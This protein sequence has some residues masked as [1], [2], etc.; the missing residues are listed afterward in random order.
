MDGDAEGGGERS[1]LLRLLR[2]AAHEPSRGLTPA[3]AL[4]LSLARAAQASVDLPLTV[5]AVQEEMLPLEAALDRLDAE[6]LLIAVE[7]PGGTAGV[8]AID[9]Q[10]RCAVVEMQTLCGLD[11]DP[12]TGRAI[13]ATDV[14]LCAPLVDAMLADLD[15]NGEATELAGWTAGMAAGARIADIRRAGLTLSSGEMRLVRLTVDLG[16]EGREGTFAMVLPPAA[17]PASDPPP[18]DTFGPR[19]RD[20]VMCAPADL[21]AVLHRMRMTW[22]EVETLTVGQVLPLAGITV[23]SVRLEGTGGRLVAQARLGRAAGL[24]AVRIGAAAPMRMEEATVPRRGMA[25]LAGADGEAA[26]A[27]AVKTASTTGPA[28]ETIVRAPLMTG[29]GDAAV[30]G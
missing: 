27:E 21:Q 2:G 16:A 7:G 5:I 1:I 17:R 9:A 23:G 18:A 29:A 30:T 11:R 15:R 6:A 12:A 14:A 19:L 13:S 22:R 25:Q 20:T 28:A 3:R 10:L 4:R 24:R 8:A 26:L